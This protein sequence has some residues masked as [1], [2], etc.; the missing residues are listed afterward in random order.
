LA[1]SLHQLL[2]E[3]FGDGGMIGENIGGGSWDEYVTQRFTQWMFDDTRIDHM[4][5][6][7][8]LFFIVAYSLLLSERVYILSCSISIGKEETM[9]VFYKLHKL[10]I[11]HKFICYGKVVGGII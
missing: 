4:S 3:F 6:L 5:R 2:K 9:F 11:L 1:I 7:Y 8:Y 10:T